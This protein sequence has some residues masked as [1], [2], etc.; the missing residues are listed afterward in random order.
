MLPVYGRHLDFG[1]GYS[2][3]LYIIEV[4]LGRP[5]VQ[6]KPHKKLLTRSADGAELPL[7]HYASQKNAPA[8]EG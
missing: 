3:Q 6:L 1:Y 4:Q 5:A 8:A 7:R 2:D